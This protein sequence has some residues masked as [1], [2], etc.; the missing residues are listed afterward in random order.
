MSYLSPPFVVFTGDMQADVSTVNNDVR[1]YDVESFKPRF[2]EPAVGNKMNGWW[3]PDGG[4]T[5]RFV[6]CAIKAYF[7]E[8][9]NSVTNE[10]INGEVSGPK[11]KPSGKMVDLDPQMQFTSELWGVGLRM[12][13]S[14]GDLIF[15]GRIEPTGFRDAQTRQFPANKDDK[16]FARNGQS[17]GGTWYSSISE[18]SWGSSSYAAKFQEMAQKGDGQLSLALHAF[19]YYYAHLDGRFSM[20]KLVGVVGTRS[21]NKQEP[22][23]FAPT[24]RLYGMLSLMSYTNFQV[25]GD[26][27]YIDFG[28]SLPLEDPLGKPLSTVGEL[29]VAVSNGTK[30][31]YKS[32]SRGIK[33]AAISIIG[34]IDVATT[35]IM[36]SGGIVKFDLDDN[37]KSL[38]ASNQLLLLFK[39]SDD[40]YLIVARESI[41]G[42][43][44]R[45]DQN[46]LRLDP[47]DE[48]PVDFYLY[49]YGK[50]I[51]DKQIALT[52]NPRTS[53]GGGG[54]GIDPP[55]APIPDINF[56]AEA[57]SS[58]IESAMSEGRV[59]Y[60]FKGSDPKKPRGYI[61]GQIYLY[62]YGIAEVP[63]IDQYFND[64][65][66]VHL[67][68][69]F[70]VPETVTWKHIEKTWIQFANLYPIM[71]KHIVDMT[72]KDALLAR[73]EILQF[74]LQ[75]DIK[76]PDYMPVTRD[77]SKNKLKAMLNWLETATDNAQTDDSAT[78]D[79]TSIS[80]DSDKSV[81][82]DS[83]AMTTSSEKTKE[84]MKKIDQMSRTKGGEISKEAPVVLDLQSIKVKD[85]HD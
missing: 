83:G 6:N 64:I 70:S 52:L 80:A 81:T 31:N 43:Y 20:S 69:E 7:D 25:K 58:S 59:R 14:N 11:D 1:H 62:S 45:A 12:S 19:G 2:Q 44:I 79:T 13:D 72:F 29:V 42:Y 54:N 10:L 35:Q 75:R 68:D 48:L 57:M 33:S 53:G 8:N 36:V 82:S 3:N 32:G 74:A 39:Q 63:V 50:P 85:C 71:S 66:M 26:A 22:V 40:E 60:S 65:V 23:R 9:G 56:P 67:R 38:L 41:D 28:M 77:L 51:S 5:F 46:V 55:T 37:N 21:D 30:L 78:V 24:R 4:A 16:Q 76:A 18:L 73:K 34:N 61:D 17:L 49:K 15:E 84:L 47:G 27:I